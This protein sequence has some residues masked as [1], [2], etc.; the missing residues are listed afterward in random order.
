MEYTDNVQFLITAFKHISQREENNRSREVLNI[1]NFE[2]N[3]LYILE[4]MFWAYRHDNGVIYK[5]IA[6]HHHAYETSQHFLTFMSMEYSTLL[7]NQSLPI[8]FHGEV[9]MNNNGSKLNIFFIREYNVETDAASSPSTVAIVEA[10]EPSSPLKNLCSVD[11]NQDPLL[12]DLNCN[13]DFL[14]LFDNDIQDFLTTCDEF[15]NI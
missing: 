15:G 7:Q 1:D 10:H 6:M 4:R 13:E 9:G 8:I 2:K 12:H 3:K 5:A 11:L 14:D